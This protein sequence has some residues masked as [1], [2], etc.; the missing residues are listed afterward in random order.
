MSPGLRT[1]SSMF[2]FPNHTSPACK[3]NSLDP[4]SSSCLPTSQLLKQNSLRESFTSLSPSPFSHPVLTTLPLG[5]PLAALV[6]LTF[7][8]PKPMFICQLSSFL[9]LPRCLILMVL[10]LATLYAL[11][12]R[13]LC[14]LVLLHQPCSS[15]P[16]AP[17]LTEG[18]GSVAAL[19]SPTSVASFSEFAHGF[20]YHL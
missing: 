9:T 2:L 12:F 6:K 8:W 18:S 15:V 11:H 16:G 3:D 1:F 5:L 17:S 20:K 13:T 14:P 4:T 19:H 7:P 10:F